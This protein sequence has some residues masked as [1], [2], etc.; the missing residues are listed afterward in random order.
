MERL[1]YSWVVL[2]ISLKEIYEVGEILSSSKDSNVVGVI[3]FSSKALH[4]VGKL[5]TRTPGFLSDV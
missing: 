4:A 5:I 1:Y 3:Q 2:D